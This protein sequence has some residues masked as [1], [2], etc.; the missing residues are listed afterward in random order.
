MP[1]KRSNEE[2]STDLSTGDQSREQPPRT[3]NQHGVPT[4]HNAGDHIRFPTPTPGASG[5]FATARHSIGSMKAGSRVG[6]ERSLA[7]VALA[8]RDSV[9]P[10]RRTPGTVTLPQGQAK[11]LVPLGVE[12]RAALSVIGFPPLC[13]EQTNKVPGHL[14]ISLSKPLNLGNVERVRYGIRGL[15]TISQKR[16]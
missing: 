1:V 4:P 7:P 15:G 8:I 13:L 14:W 10:V 11:L 2:G 16:L 6:R 12:D 9:V 3:L 5:S